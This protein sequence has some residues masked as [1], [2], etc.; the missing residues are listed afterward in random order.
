[1]LTWDQR[2]HML[3]PYLNIV[4]LCIYLFYSGEAQEQSEITIRPPAVFRPLKIVNSGHWSHWELA[5]IIVNIIIADCFLLLRSGHCQVF[6]RKLGIIVISG[7][8]SNYWLGWITSQVSLSSERVSKWDSISTSETQ[9][10][11][12][13]TE[14]LLRREWK[15]IRPIHLVF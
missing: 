2:G 15:T 11:L 1:M 9:D 12:V 14:L 8:L 10:T 5:Q 7:Q 4:R 6:L 13:A 3:S